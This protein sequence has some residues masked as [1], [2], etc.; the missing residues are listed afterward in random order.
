MRV[1]VGSDHAG[2]EGRRAAVEVLERLGADVH[3][4][5]TPGEASDYPDH[6]HPVARAVV[7]GEARFGVLVCGTG[8]GMAMAANRHRGVRAAVITDELTARLARAHNDANIA[9][10]G[11]R[12]IGPQ[13]IRELLPIF[14]ETS[15]DG[16]RHRVR[17]G[18][19]EVAEGPLPD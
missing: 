9:C 8:L 6:A 19:I 2:V 4:L 10:F 15:F 1:A 18:K 3:E 12:V 5:G 7:A 11:E 13:R 14:L 17:V 16:G